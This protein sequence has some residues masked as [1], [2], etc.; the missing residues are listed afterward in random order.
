MCVCENCFQLILFP[1][2]PRLSASAADGKAVVP[3]TVP[4][5][6]GRGPKISMSGRT[7]SIRTDV[8]PAPGKYDALSAF[9]KT[10][11]RV[12]AYSMSARFHRIEKDPYFV[13]SEVKDGKA[14]APLVVKSLIGQGPKYSMSGRTRQPRDHVTPGPGNY[15]GP[16]ETFGKSAPRFTMSAR[17]NKG[18]AFGF[19]GGEPR[20]RE[21]V[22]LPQLQVV[23]SR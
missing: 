3:P 15:G 7:R 17:V 8:T 6:F 4:T 22:A 20:L 10:A 21:P 19:F 14:V 5:S 16:T 2:P 12:P 11:Q 1:V 13:E 23:E 9:A 18:I